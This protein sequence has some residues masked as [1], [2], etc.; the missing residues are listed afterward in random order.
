V[1]DQSATPDAERLVAWL[2]QDIAESGGTGRRPHRAG[3]AL[4]WDDDRLRVAIH[5]AD[6]HRLLTIDTESAR[7]FGFVYLV[8]AE[9]SR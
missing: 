6:A 5:Q 7:D 2:R 1:S 3:W 9:A 4:G 8:P